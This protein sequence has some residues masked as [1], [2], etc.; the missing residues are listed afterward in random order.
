MLTSL[1]ILTTN[2]KSE[3]FLSL[4]FILVNTSSP[5]IILYK[6][7]VGTKMESGTHLVPQLLL[8]QLSGLLHERLL[9]AKPLLHIRDPCQ[10][11]IQGLQC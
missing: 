5:D 1:H 11:H 8:S 4:D 10:L 9:G 2:H 6:F 3:N 7:L